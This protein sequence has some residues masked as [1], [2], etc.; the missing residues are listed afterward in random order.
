MK[1]EEQEK[2]KELYFEDENNKL[3]YNSNF[4]LLFL[5]LL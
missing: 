1:K 2:I 4:Y 5:I 3:A